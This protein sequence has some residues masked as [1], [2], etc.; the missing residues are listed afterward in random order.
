MAESGIHAPFGDFLVSKFISLGAVLS[1]SEKMLR[2]ARTAQDLGPSGSG[3][4]I[5]WLDKVA[6]TAENPFSLWPIF[7]IIFKIYFFV[8]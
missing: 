6:K 5:P 7:E 4:W 3:A 1:E 2:Y 8:D